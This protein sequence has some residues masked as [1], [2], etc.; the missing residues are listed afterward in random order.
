MIKHL[1]TQDDYIKELELCK[2]LVIKNIEESHLCDSWDGIPT[3]ITP[4]D[5][6]WN[7]VKWCG[8]LKSTIWSSNRTSTKYNFITSYGAK[9]ECERALK[10]YVAN[11]WMKLAMIYAGLEVCNA[12]CV[13]YDSG[14]LHKIPVKWE[15]I[16]I[17]SENF[18]FRRKPKE[19]YSEAVI[20]HDDYNCIKYYCLN[21]YSE[22]KK[23]QI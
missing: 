13:D 3:N 19:H 20:V 15:D 7:I 14:K 23:Y 11:N 4:E 12:N 1:K 18:I 10:C 6:F 17:N 5:H 9:H 2:S 21:E 22:V 8:K 16:L